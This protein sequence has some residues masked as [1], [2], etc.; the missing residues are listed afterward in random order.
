MRGSRLMAWSLG[1]LAVL[2]AACAAMLSVTVDDAQAR[3]SAQTRDD[4]AQAAAETSAALLTYT[5]DTVAADQYAAGERLT[6][7][8]RARYGQFTDTVVV[9]TSRTNRVTST[10]TV[11]ATGVSSVDGDDAEAL[12]FLTQVTST[13]AAPDPVT[14]KVGARVDLTR[15]DGRW[16]V[17]D[18][19][20]S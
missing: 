15:I 5:P 16:L 17:S 13:D 8:F 6:G 11:T 7:D 19:E 20:P 9:P 1:V 10:A 2:L 14:T 12:V 18:F 3:V 4:V